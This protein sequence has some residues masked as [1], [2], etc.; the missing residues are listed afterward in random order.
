MADQVADKILQGLSD[1]KNFRLMWL[2]RLGGLTKW[3]ALHSA[4]VAVKP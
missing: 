1:L 2:D 3:V 4:V